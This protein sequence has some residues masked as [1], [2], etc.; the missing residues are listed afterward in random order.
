[1][2]ESNDGIFH[3]KDFEML[4]SNVFYNLNFLLV[5]FILL[6]H[7]GQHREVY[8]EF[9]PLSAAGAKGF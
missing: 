8:R 1:M 7:E 2:R 3:L 9:Q 6:T 4:A 5:R